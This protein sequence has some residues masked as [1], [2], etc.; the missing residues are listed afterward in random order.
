MANVGNIPIVGQKVKVSSATSSVSS[1]QIELN[2]R[3]A[4]TSEGEVAL[5]AVL[6]EWAIMLKALAKTAFEKAGYTVTKTKLL[7][8]SAIDPKF[9]AELS[10]D[11]Y[12][13]YRKV[14]DRGLT[15]TP[16]ERLYSTMLACHHVVAQGIAGDFV[17]C[18]VWRGGNAL[19]AANIF[20]RRDQRRLAYLYDTFT[21]MTEPTDADKDMEN[22]PAVERADTLRDANGIDWCRAS[23]EDVQ[24]SF[25]RESL[26]AQARFIKGDVLETL[27][28]EAN[29]P[30]QI[31]VLRLDTDWHDSTKLELEILYPRLSSGGI[32]IVDDYGHWQGSRKAVDEYFATVERPFFQY[33]DYGARAGIKP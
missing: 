18:G 11:D 30:K 12:A 7:Q 20:K 26:L 19:L 33:T 3:L 29:L 17:E 15:M 5:E 28:V 4:P 6:W 32:L 10:A 9:P 27:R 16:P 14:T 8:P 22:A 21:G 25:R 23:I 13:I 2:L 31:S 24:S 1:R